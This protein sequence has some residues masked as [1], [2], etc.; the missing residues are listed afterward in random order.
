MNFADASPESKLNAASVMTAIMELRIPL[1]NFTNCPLTSHSKCWSMKSHHGG[2]DRR[3]ALIPCRVWNSYIASS[4]FPRSPSGTT[5]LHNAG[6]SRW[7][8]FNVCFCS[9]SCSGLGHVGLPQFRAAY[10]AATLISLSRRRR[11]RPAVWPAGIARVFG[12]VCPVYLRPDNRPRSWTA[13]G[14]T[15]F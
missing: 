2:P 10:S 14:V 5:I 13:V 8:A 6:Q 9:G 11:F 7:T 4:R 3:C 12:R 15:R 1:P